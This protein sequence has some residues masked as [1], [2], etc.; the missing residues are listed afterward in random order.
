M[1]AQERNEVVF[2]PEQR[3]ILGQV[4]QLIISWR[5]ERLSRGQKQ[6][7]PK[8]TEEKDSPTQC[9]SGSTSPTEGMS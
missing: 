1:T 8:P 7:Q 2:T 9:D 6:G 5:R 4:Y 3:H